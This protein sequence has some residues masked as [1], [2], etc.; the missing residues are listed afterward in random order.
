M[1]TPFVYKLGTDEL[2]ECPNFV[3]VWFKQCHIERGTQAERSG[4]SDVEEYILE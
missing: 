1:D 2:R 3:C 4:E